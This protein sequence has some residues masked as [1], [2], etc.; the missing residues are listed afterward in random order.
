VS[1]T[2]GKRIRSYVPMEQEP[3]N[4]TLWRERHVCS[5]GGVRREGRIRFLPPMRLDGEHSSWAFAWPNW[6]PRWM[7]RWSNFSWTKG[8]SLVRFEAWMGSISSGSAPAA[9]SE[10]TSGSRV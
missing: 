2:L 4:G 10:S 9:R 5:Q 3:N 1:K 7:F 6:Y 8:R